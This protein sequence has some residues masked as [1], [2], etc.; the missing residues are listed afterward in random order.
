MTWAVAPYANSE[1]SIA[2]TATTATDVSGGVEYYFDETSGHAGSS[3]SGWQ[4]SPDYQDTGLNPGTQ[5]TYHVKARD[6]FYN[7]GA[8]SNPVT[9]TAS[10]GPAPGALLH[11]KADA[12]VITD[13]VGVLTWQD[14][15]GNSNHASRSFGDPQ[16]VTAALPGGNRQVVRF[17]G[18]DVFLLADSA[19]LRTTEIS[20]YAVLTVTPADRAEYFGNYSNAIN[21]GYGFSM[22][23]MPDRTIHNGTY[24]GT[25]P[26]DYNDWW[27]PAVP[28]ADPYHIIT[29]TISKTGLI[30]KTYAD[31]A[32]LGSTSITNFAYN[33][34]TIACV[35]SLLGWDLFTF[36]GDFAEILVY[37]SVSE[38]QRTQVEQ[39]LRDKYMQP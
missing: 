31:G 39:Y 28:G 20:V 2:M 9:V 14:Q 22:G 33:S 1:T 8:Y 3:D 26:P 27:S 38:S 15:S 6:P 21:W 13:S 16:L 36:E 32:L 23:T 25:P 18:S 11:L 37:P 29:N 35:G 4:S 19:A 5:Y 24:A 10:Y 12:G 30:K 34:D 7:E 17:N